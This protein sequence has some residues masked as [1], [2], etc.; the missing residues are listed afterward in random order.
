MTIKR[1]QYQFKDGKTTLSAETFNA[2]FFDLDARLHGLEQLEVSWED[3]VSELQQYGLSRINGALGPVLDQ[4]NKDVAAVEQEKADITEW[5]NQT[6]ADLAAEKTSLEDR[7]AALSA[8]I[9]GEIIKGVAATAPLTV[10]STDPHNPIISDNMHKYHDYG[11]SADGDIT[12]SISDGSYGTGHVL[13]AGNTITVDL[14]STPVGPT[15]CLIIVPT[16]GSIIW[17]ASIHWPGGVVPSMV[18]GAGSYRFV[19]QKMP[20]NYAQGALV[21]APYA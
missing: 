6:I 10:D 3:A 20:G 11:T 8:E 5:W 2:V 12:I 13:L 7:F 1:T 17:D 16:S 21:G 19:F 18:N 14:S 9:T 15:F 4:A